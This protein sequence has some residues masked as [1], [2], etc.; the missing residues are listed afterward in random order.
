MKKSIVILFVAVSLICAACSNTDEA[1]AITEFPSE[2]QKTWNYSSAADDE[3]K[4]YKINSTTINVTYGDG[5]TSTYRFL[6]GTESYTTTLSGN[7]WTSWYIIMAVSAG[8]DAGKE[9]TSIF[10]YRSG[11]LRI[12]DDPIEYQ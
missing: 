2:L 12:D 5:V 1:T 6:H 4:T 7:Q 3:V 9:V 8:R 10:H 11:K